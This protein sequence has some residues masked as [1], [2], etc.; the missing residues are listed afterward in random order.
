MTFIVTQDGVVYQKD[1]GKKTATFGKTTREYNP[2]SEWRK[3][4]Q[5][6]Q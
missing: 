3:A 4:E 6:P 2:D 1:L 5:E